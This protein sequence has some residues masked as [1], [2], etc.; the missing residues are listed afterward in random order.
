[1]LTEFEICGEGGEESLEGLNGDHNENMTKTS[2]PC[3]LGDIDP[4]TRR[5]S[6]R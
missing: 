4:A 6:C 5:G 1:M 3:P 2:A